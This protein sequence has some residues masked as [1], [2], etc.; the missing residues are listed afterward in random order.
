MCVG[1][2]ASAAC[3]AG[4]GCCSCMCG[5]CKGCGV[6]NKVFAK[7]GYV[8][9]SV[10][11]ILIAL[12]M[13]WT[14]K[15]LFEHWIKFIHCPGGSGTA[16]F[17]ISAVF[18][19]SFVLFLFH[20][21]TFLF[22]LSR[23]QWAAYYHDALWGVKFFIVLILFIA[24]FWIPN[25]FF[26]YYGD[27]SRVLS[28]FFLV[29]QTVIML[30]V[31]Y[32]IN[33]SLIDLYSHEVKSAGILLIIL[34]VIVYA[35]TIIWIVLQYVWFWS[36][37]SNLVIISIVVFFGIGFTVCLLLRTREDISILTNGMVM[38]YCTYLSWSA[39]ATRPT[40]SCNRFTD[41]AGNTFAQ[42]FC[43]LG[44]TMLA[45][46]GLSVMSA[47][48]DEE[49]KNGAAA[50]NSALIEKVDEAESRD[51]ENAEPQDP[52]VFEISTATIWF[53][54]LMMFASVYYC[55]LITNWGN[56]TI[57]ADQTGYF[58]SNWLSFWVKICAQ[59]VSFLLYLFSLLGPV[60]FPNR[61]WY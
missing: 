57:E 38:L 17:G 15:P 58:A 13:L 16:C 21:L 42:I 51:V 20:L 14:I 2:C 33:E 56:P 44:F 53:H 10:F 6:H 36:C 12:I 31:A 52:H 61:E 30:S 43:G 11:W 1:V 24:F 27:V 40:D 32:K 23:M 9:F 46:F 45:L 49:V 50:L 5:I 55:M 48:S 7:I 29:Y 37:W 35:G 59:W 25:S 19:M 28:F 26:K 18:R 4:A 34:T 54:V 8:F 60:I 39:L 41:S 22:V 47:G 3:C